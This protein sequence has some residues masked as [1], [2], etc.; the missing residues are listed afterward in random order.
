MDR[1][2]WRVTAH[3]VAKSQ[4]RLRNSHT[5]FLLNVPLSCWGSHG[6]VE[7]CKLKTSPSTRL[8]CPNAALREGHCY[9]CRDWTGERLSPLDQYHLGAA[10]GHISITPSGS[11]KFY[12]A[13]EVTWVSYRLSKPGNWDN[14]GVAAGSEVGLGVFKPN[15]S[16]TEN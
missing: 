5:Y 2:A 15:Y 16:L 9:L 1:G 14:S 3:G 6:W 4:T 8:S 12:W 7:E 11:E 10:E 13:V